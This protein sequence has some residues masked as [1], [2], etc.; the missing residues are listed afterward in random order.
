MFSPPLDIL[1]IFT[2]TTPTV[3]W[4]STKIR[5]KSLCGVY[6]VIGLAA[7]GYEIYKLSSHA[8]SEPVLIPLEAMPFESCLRI[9]G[10]SI[11]M[12]SIFIFLSF[13][14]ALYSIRYMERD[15]GTTLYYTLL[16]AMICGLLGAVFS[17]D[18]FTLFVFWE[19]M[20]ITSYML[21]AFRKHHWEPIEAGLKY[22]VMSSAGS[23]TILLGLSILYG[24]TGTLNFTGLATVATR[25]SNIWCSISLILLIVGFGV[26]AS[27]FPF[28]TWLPDAHPAAPTPISALLSGIVIKAGFYAILRSLFTFFPPANFSW[29]TALAVISILTMS[30]GNLAALLQDD[31]KRL[32]AYSSI[33]Q[34]GY[35][36]FAISAAAS[37]S[38]LTMGLTAAL[39]HVLNHA[40]MKGLLF[41]CAGAFIYR[42]GTRSL[43]ELAGIGHKMPLTAI[44]F[45][46][47]ALAISGIPSLNGFVS[48]LMIVYAGIQANMPFYT[49]IL[50]I[51]ILLGFAYY[52]RL[53]KMIIWS[54]PSKGLDKVKEAPILMLASILAL[55]ITCILIG[56]YPAPFI[57]VS[58]K[59]AN[60][61]I[62]SLK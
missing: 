21:V 27:I 46:I 56:V 62:G 61:L 51:N 13:F 2:L 29:Q 54:T 50:L 39:L 3:G 34:I 43:K 60:A 19:L 55:T 23:A 10:L 24:L 58:S 12:A 28:H 32:L 37:P 20:C 22:L 41:L 6:A 38:A 8:F 1:L 25:M 53:I 9:D 57:E 52:L 15:S 47:G 36:F 18:F 35:I 44:A 4:V 31:I 59:A 49:A 11:F 14:A 33:A 5:L 40:L 48:E 7:S 42:A 26:K 16:L 30:F 17:G 45:T